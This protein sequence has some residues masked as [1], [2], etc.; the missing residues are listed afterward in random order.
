MTEPSKHLS[1]GIIFLG[2]ILPW[3]GAFACIATPVGDL[4]LPYY[5]VLLFYFLCW[6][7]TMAGILIRRPKWGAALV[8]GIGALA[9]IA[10]ELVATGLL[11]VY[12]FGLKGVF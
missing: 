3:I 9:L 8:L 2:L 7:I 10:C 11:C 5:Y 4:V 6:T 1:I 12:L